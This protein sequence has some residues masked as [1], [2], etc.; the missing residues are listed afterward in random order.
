MIV[1][2]YF[3]TLRYYHYHY[4]FHHRPTQTSKT[5]PMMFF[6]SIVCRCCVD[7]PTCCPA[8]WHRS[9]CRPPFPRGPAS[10]P[11]RSAH[12]ETGNNNGTT[13]NKQRCSSKNA[14]ALQNMT[15]YMQHASR[16]RKRIIIAARGWLRQIT[17]KRLQVT[18][19]RV[20]ISHNIYYNDSSGNNNWLI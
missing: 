15:I 2:F 12:E 5:C 4:H 13:R 11:A 8:R 18:K 14:L 1:E 20:S 10:G 19:R 9:P 3:F 16:G 17:G 6:S 7:S